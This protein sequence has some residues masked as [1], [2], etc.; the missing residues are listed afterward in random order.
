MIVLYGLRVGVAYSPAEGVA[1]DVREHY[2]S[3]P[4]RETEELLSGGG[5][6]Q[7]TGS[8]GIVV[9]VHLRH[10][11]VE[12]LCHEDLHTAGSSASGQRRAHAWPA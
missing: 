8:S 7:L 5:E 10:I 2:E 12:T 4:H 6:G 11:A 1:E 3:E 9:D